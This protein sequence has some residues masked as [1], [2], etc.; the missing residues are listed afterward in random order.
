MN[1]NIDGILESL[2]EAVKES[3]EYKEFLRIQEL[4]HNE[5]E[6]ERAVNE[7]RR[8][9]FEIHKRRDVDRLE[10]EFAPLRLEPLVN[11][12]LTAELALC[13]IVQRINYRLMQEIEFDLGFE[14]M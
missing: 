5:P 9:N 1:Q 6:K 13:R 3:E 12:Y 14:H 10:Q 7:F 2:V 4:I 8:R 11:D